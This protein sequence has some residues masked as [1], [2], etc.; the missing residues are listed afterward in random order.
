M[1]R[2]VAT[3][4]HNSHVKKGIPHKENCPICTSNKITA[5]DKTETGKQFRHLA[6]NYLYRLETENLKRQL[7]KKQLEKYTEHEG[8]LY[9]Q[10]RLVQESSPTVADLDFS[11]FYDSPD[12]KTLLPV[13]SATSALFFSFCMYV[14]LEIRLH[15]GVERCMREIL[16][17]I[18]P[19]HNPRAVIQKI[20]QNCVKCRIIEKKTCELRMRSHPSTR[21]T[22]APVFYNLQLDI[23]YGFVSKPHR[24]ARTT[25]PIYALVG[26]CLLSSASSI[27]AL[28][29]L[30]T[31]EVILALE[32]HCSRYGVPNTCFVDN[33]SQLLSLQ[34]TEF[35]LREVHANVSDSLGL[36]IMP[37]TPK[38]H[39]SNGRVEAKIKILRSTLEKLSINPKSPQT[40]LHWETLFSKIAAQMDDVPICKA[41]SSNVRDEFWELITPN[42]LKL[43]RN[44]YR[45][46][47]G[48]IV[49]SQE[50][51][52]TAILERNQNLQ[53][54]WYRTFL[55]HIHHL[56]ARPAKWL[57]T[58]K[59]EIGCIVLFVFNE[60]KLGNSWRIG[61]VVDNPVEN[62]LIIE[63]CSN[64]TYGKNGSFK[65]D[66]I[67]RSPRDV[68]VLFNANDV[69]LNSNDYYKTLLENATPF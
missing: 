3:F 35:N 69:L 33:G 63:Y 32:R 13:V 42:R 15:C 23:C 27:M 55:S 9:M 50:V 10:S 25:M 57:D 17:H 47:E 68:S 29:S 64:R 12:I 60:S 20:R 61:R 53:K 28:E 58:D 37:T 24:Q 65:L 66:K 26:V 21:T 46:L 38:N 51:G 22:L 54:L 62:K 67:V 49:L 43:G 8:I 19:L 31:Q 52:P 30:E 2:T 18:F 40:A 6:K 45:S 59:I 34:N 7:P 48:S 16:K 11:L 44:M 4:M 39:P 36:T 1:L 41:S 14:H 56:I 5:G